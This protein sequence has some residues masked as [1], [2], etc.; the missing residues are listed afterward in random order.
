MVSR[1][2]DAYIPDDKFKLERGDTITLLG[3]NHTVD[4]ALAELRL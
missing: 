2:G 3:Q 4:E 1:D